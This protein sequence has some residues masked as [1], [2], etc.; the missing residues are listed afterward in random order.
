MTTE[1]NRTRTAHSSRGFTLAELSIYMGLFGVLA[2]VAYGF[3]R[4]DLTL[5]AKNTSI[6]QTHTAMR[7][8]LNRLAD[9]LQQARDIPDLITATGSPTSG[10]AA[11]LSFDRFI[12]TP[13][14]V[15]HPGGAGL[16]ASATSITVARSTNPLASPP[17]PQAGELMLIDAPDQ[18]VRAR[19]ASVSAAAINVAAQRQSILITLAAPLG[20]AVTWNAGTP[21]TADLARRVAFIAVPVVGKCELRYFKQFEPMPSLSDPANYVVISDQLSAQSGETTPFS[22]DASTSDKLVKV[23]LRARTR[24]YSGWLSKRQSNGFNTFTAVNSTMPSRLR[25]KQ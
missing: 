16:S 3:L 19:V 15:T 2:A 11:G 22:I 9:E 13:Y 1:M 6:N 14:V 12:G 25:P 8:S 17:I 10:S 20:T 18:P 23:S 21:K 5:V 7:S 24:E 4:S